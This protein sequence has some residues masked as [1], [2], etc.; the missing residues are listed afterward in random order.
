MSSLISSS[1]TIEGLKSNK[2]IIMFIKTGKIGP[3]AV[4]N[5][6]QNERCKKLIEI[7]TVICTREPK[8]AQKGNKHTSTINF[9]R[10]KLD[11]STI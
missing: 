6:N 11:R 8:I 5:S 4:R 3:I 10:L 9:V 7:L 2:K 1:Q